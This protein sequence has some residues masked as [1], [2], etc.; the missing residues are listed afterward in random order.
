MTGWQVACAS[1]AFNAGTFIQGL[2]SLSNQGYAPKGW[3]TTLLAFAVLAFAVLINIAATTS[4]AKFEGLILVLHILGFFAVLIPLVNFAPHDTASNVF[5][6]FLN[7]NGWRT[8]SYAFFISLVGPV[9][10]FVGGDCAVHMA[11]EIR[12]AAVIVPRAIMISTFLNGSLGFGML[13]AVLFCL[14]EASLVPTTILST[15]LGFPFIQVLLDATRNIPG[16]AVMASIVLIMGISSTVGLLATASRLLWAFSRD[17][18]MPFWGTI[19]KVDKRTSIPVPAVLITT[20]ISAL[21]ALISIGSSTA[22][23]DV[24]SITVVGLYSSYIMPLALLLW[25]RSTGTI[26]HEIDQPCVNDDGAVNTKNAVLI[27]GPF[28]VPHAM[29]IIVNATALVYLV[30]VFLFAFW[31]TAQPVTPATMNYACLLWGAVILASLI[32]YA[33]VARKV[34]QGPVVEL[35]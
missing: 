17:R 3:R 11:E 14:G 5:T 31:P 20:S 12:N 34:Y 27:W 4:L 2:I 21:L 8:Q 26:H 35:P 18:S 9:Y 6:T 25:R 7:P 16:T 32:W 23:N 33:A 24:I 1:G 29:G 22:F 10:G 30:I 13:I 15:S 28:A 19:S